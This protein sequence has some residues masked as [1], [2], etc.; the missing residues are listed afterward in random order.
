MFT[1]KDT[2]GAFLVQEASV[3]SDCKC[4]GV[5]I[6]S[7]PLNS[8]ER[9]QP[10]ARTHTHTTQCTLFLN[11]SQHCWLLNA[12]RYIYADVSLFFLNVFL[13]K[14]LICL[15]FGRPAMKC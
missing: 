14:V 6:F 10:D 3:Y 11:T 12:V 5:K 8:A 13:F 15:L 9:V 7:L 4:T 2:H 1:N